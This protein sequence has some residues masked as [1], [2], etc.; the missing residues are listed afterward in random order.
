ML[1]PRTRVVTAPTDLR[2]LRRECTSPRRSTRQHRVSSGPSSVI[3]GFRECA[4]RRPT[5]AARGV[6]FMRL[7]NAGRSSTADSTSTNR[8]TGMPR[9]VNVNAS[10][11]SIRRSNWGSRS[12][13]GPNHGKNSRKFNQVCAIF[14]SCRS[15][16]SGSLRSRK[17]EHWFQSAGLPSVV[18]SPLSTYVIAGTGVRE[19]PAPGTRAA[20]KMTPIL[21][22][23][24]GTQA[25]SGFRLPD[26]HPDDQAHLVLLDG[27][28]RLG[29]L[30]RL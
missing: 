20:D 1:S 25:V 15:I 8:A 30:P 4:D 26:T 23:P 22:G 17:R 19:G 21:T 16:E 9:R 6:A 2:F 5:T 12:P 13:Q 10:R 11:S 3:M 29:R 24:T 18:S 14:R 7:M 27:I 28:E